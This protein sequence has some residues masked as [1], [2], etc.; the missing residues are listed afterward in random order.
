MK[1]AYSARLIPAGRNM[2]YRSAALFVNFNWIFARTDTDS[3]RDFCRG[4][5]GTRH[6]L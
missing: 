2:L 4:F 5:E 1:Q 3:A 6:H